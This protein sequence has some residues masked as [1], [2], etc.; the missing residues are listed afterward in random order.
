DAFCHNMVRSLVGCLIAVGEG[1]QEPAWA[2][3]MLTARKRNSSVTVARA[4]GL[5]L[6]EVR[7]PADADLAARATES[8]AMRTLTPPLGSPGG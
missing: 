5:T 6:E 4:H 7:Y 1:R 8:R 3:E 2:F